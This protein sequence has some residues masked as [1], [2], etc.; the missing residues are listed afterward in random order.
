MAIWYQDAPEVKYPNLFFEVSNLILFNLEV[1]N[2][3][4][5]QTEISLL[6]KKVLESLNNE[7]I[8][9]ENYTREEHYWAQLGTIYYEIDSFYKTKLADSIAKSLLPY[10]YR[11]LAP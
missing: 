5:T 4:H 3:E 6:R 9:Q 8:N 7:G 2:I 1:H 10:D 11:G